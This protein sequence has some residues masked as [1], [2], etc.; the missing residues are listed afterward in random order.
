MNIIQFTHNYKQTMWHGFTLTAVELGGLHLS[1][2]HL[3]M[4]R[5]SLGHGHLDEL[6]VVELSNS[7]EQQKLST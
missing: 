6:S 3:E 1:V 2:P 5:A 4:E 7:V